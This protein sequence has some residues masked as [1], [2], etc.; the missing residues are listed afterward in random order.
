MSPYALG[1]FVL[2]L[3]PLLVTPGAS[4]ALLVRHVVDGG[5]RRALGVALGTATGIG[6]HAL[7]AAAGLS[8]LV[9]RSAEAYTAVRLVGAAYLIGLGMWTWHSVRRAPPT[10]GG[11]KS[12]EPR[13]RSV[14]GQ[15]LL[16]NVL[17]LKAAAIYLTLVPQFVD[18]GGWVA[19]QI[20]A[21]A[22]V[23]A[24]LT[25]AWLVGW[26]LVVDR[27]AHALRRERTRRMVARVS[28]AALVAVGLRT[29]AA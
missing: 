23:H 26:S 16:A 9:M 17:N 13:G 12:S 3:L 29:A 22:T 15:A 18:P 1:G 6:A 24:L 5:R 7:L 28:G 25:T 21:L 4:M 20:L 8:A 2:A 14:Y 27:S 11:K 10:K 19:G